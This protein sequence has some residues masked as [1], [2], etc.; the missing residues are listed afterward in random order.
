MLVVGLSNGEV[1][2]LI[3]TYRCGLDGCFSVR[4]V[5]SCCSARCSE[6][7]SSTNNSNLLALLHGIRLIAWHFL[8][9]ESFSYLF[10][11]SAPL[12]AV[13]KGLQSGLVKTLEAL[14]PLSFCQR[15]YREWEG[16]LTDVKGSRCSLSQLCRHSLTVI[17][18]SVPHTSPFEK[19]LFFNFWVQ[20]LHYDPCQSVVAG[21][22]ELS[23]FGA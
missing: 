16:D 10:N 8:S 12:W 18:L 23:W 15:W 5:C 20:I 17:L 3:H 19:N 22:L 2:G 7:F 4:M 9:L 1:L 11:F 6:C 21:S 13:S 14:N